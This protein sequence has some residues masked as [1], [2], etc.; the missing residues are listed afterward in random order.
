MRNRAKCRL[1]QSVI[2]SFHNYDYVV[3]KCGEISVDGGNE[4][5]K[6]GALDWK[7]FMRVDDEGNEIVPIIKDKEE[8]E[9]TESVPSMKPTKKD[10]LQMLDE[11]IKS[12]ER[13]PDHAKAIP[14]SH[15]DFISAL[16]LLSSVLRE[17]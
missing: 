5:F 3:C 11:M 17:D 7:N 8:V 2:E 4:Y 1:C 10:L 16:L 6:C 12:Y 14:I 9:K 15:Y 13:L